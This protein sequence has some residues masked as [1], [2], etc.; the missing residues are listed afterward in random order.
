MP[1]S[2]APLQRVSGQNKGDG[3]V[4]INRTTNTK[5]DLKGE[6]KRCFNEL[7]TG[8]ADEPFFIS[9]EKCLEI[10]QGL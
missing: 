5:N 4:L 3:T 9:E 10:N 7:I 1:E 2:K 6:L 8:T